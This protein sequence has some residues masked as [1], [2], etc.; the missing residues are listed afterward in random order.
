LLLVAA[1]AALLA[2]LARQRPAARTPLRVSLAV[3]IAGL[4]AFELSTAAREG[5][6]TWKTVLPF[7]LCDAALVLSVFTLLVPRRATAELVYFWA[8]SG[9][10]LAMLTPELRWGFPRWEFV[11]F[12]G[13]HGLVLAAALLLVFGLGLHP[14]RGAPLRVL[15]ITA[16]WAGFVAVVNLLLGTNFMYLR[17]KPL[18]PTPLDWMGPWPVYILT[19]ALLAFTLFSLLSLPF[20]R[21][22]RAASA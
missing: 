2:A 18:V 14:R 19:A 10:L 21:E 5:W 16:A 1:I 17:R 7:E 20:R 12:F 15:A 3:A 22:W 9:S 4:V 6:L 11:V 8:G 13:L